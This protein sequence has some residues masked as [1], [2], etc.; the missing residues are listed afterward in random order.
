MLMR[1]ER[2]LVVEYGKKSVEAGLCIGTAGNISIYDPETGNM[3]IKPSGLGYFDTLP[4]DIVVM[5][6]DDFVNEFKLTNEP[7]FVKPV[8]TKL[9]DGILI[10]KEEHLSYLRFNNC[11]VLVSKPIDIVSE[12]RVYVHNK[13]ATGNTPIAF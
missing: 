7:M 6:L 5:K 10:S 8:Q 12:H 11:E 2:E 3:V 13:K 1:K 9:F 4:E